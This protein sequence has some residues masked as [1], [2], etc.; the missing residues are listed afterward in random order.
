MAVP[1]PILNNFSISLENIHVAIATDPT[2]T[3]PLLSFKAIKGALFDPSGFAYKVTKDVSGIITDISA[4]S[5]PNVQLGHLIQVISNTG[6][7]ANGDINNNS[8]PMTYKFNNGQPKTIL[9][10]LTYANEY[11]NVSRSIGAH[12]MLIVAHIIACRA[13]VTLDE[14][15]DASSINNEINDISNKIAEILTNHMNT[16]NVQNLIL[17]RIIQIMGPVID[18]NDGFLPY[19]DNYIDLDILLDIRNLTVNL[20]FNDIQKHISILSLPIQLQIRNS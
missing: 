11:L 7:W 16:S 15:F 13:P 4:M 14:I 8:I 1:P 3:D 20:T 6:L 12:I 5:R 2:I 18:T 17:Q 10:D 19:I 9:Y